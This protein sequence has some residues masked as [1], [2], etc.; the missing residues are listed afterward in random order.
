[1]IRIFRV[2]VPTSVLALIVSETI[3][4]FSCFILSSYFVL[5]ADPEVFLLYDGG[6]L[7][8]TLVVLSVMLGLYFQD[9]YTNF[10]VRSKLVLVQQLCLVIGIVF[11]SQALLTYVSP[12]L[13]MSRW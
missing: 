3:L 4:I 1:M 12:S 13:M 7:R 8:V 2:F 11:F 5:D 10:R 6:L 9:L